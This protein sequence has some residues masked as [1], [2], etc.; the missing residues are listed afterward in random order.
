MDG[1]H[2]SD[3]LRTEVGETTDQHS[4]RPLHAPGAIRDQA[5][6]FRERGAASDSAATATAAICSLCPRCPG[7]RIGRYAETCA[8][9]SAQPPPRPSSAS[10][11]KPYD[12]EQVNPNQ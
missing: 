6:A 4:D 2:A 7:T 8:D 10:R 5:V 3:R 1:R 9:F 12:R 11:F